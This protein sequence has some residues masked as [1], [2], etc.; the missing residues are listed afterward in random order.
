MKIAQ[1]QQLLLTTPAESMA[2]VGIGL[3]EHVTFPD[4]LKK[5]PKQYTRDY[6]KRPEIFTRLAEVGPLRLTSM[7][8]SCTAI[9]VLSWA[10]AGA[11]KLKGAD[12]VSFAKEVNDAMWAC[13][14]NSPDPTRFMAFAHLPTSEP[15]AAATELKRCVRRGFVGALV[16]GMQQGRCMDDP[17][18]APIL[19]CAEKL[20]VPIYIHPGAPPPAVKNAYHYTTPYLNENAAETLSKAGWSWHSEVGLQVMRM[21]YSGTFDRH[22]K[23]KIVIGHNG[24]MIPMFMQRADSMCE[25]LGITRPISETLRKH[26]WVSISGFFYMPS[27]QCAIDA[28]GI[29]HVTWSVDY[30]WVPFAIDQGKEFVKQLSAIM[31]HD[32]LNK[33]MYGNAKALLKRR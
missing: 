13:I 29:D 9:Q 4:L 27:V 21:C 28:F 17:Y 19:S 11:D 12:A 5:L 18:F 32:D 8:K 7:D 2:C 16:V 31:S 15:E 33:I 1:K 24:E 20:D 23:L 26:V 6:K 14:K 10:G 30:P 22:P 3:E 25:Q